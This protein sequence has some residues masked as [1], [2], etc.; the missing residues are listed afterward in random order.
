MSSSF[1]KEMERLMLKV[2]LITIIFSLSSCSS[3]TNYNDN[4]DREVSVRSGRPSYMLLVPRKK[5][6]GS[7]IGGYR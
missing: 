5:G 6:R 7:Y 3:S 2:F 1:S 4:W